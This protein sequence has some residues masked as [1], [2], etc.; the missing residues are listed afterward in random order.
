MWE[1]SQ[2]K[3]SIKQRT[4][5][6]LEK[7]F[8]VI[9]MTILTL[10]F[11]IFFWAEL[12]FDVNMPNWDDYDSV[13]NWLATFEKTYGV[14]RIIDMLFRQHN[15]HRILF[16]RLIELTELYS[17]KTV[18]F[19][20]LDI[21]GALG[22]F[23]IVLFILFLGKR[24]GLR[25]W[26]MIPIPFILL[27]FSQNNLISFSMASIQVYWAILF[28]FLSFFFV[29]K[30]SNFRYTLVGF[31]FSTLASFTS[32]GGLIGFPVVTIYYLFNKKYKIALAWTAC[33]III[34]YIYFVYF[35]YH[36]TT[37]GIASH[38]YAYSHPLEYFL[39]VIRFYGNMARIPL[40]AEI[41]GFFLIFFSTIFLFGNVV[42]R[43]SWFFLSGTF[44][45][46]TGLADGLS[47]ISLGLNAGLASRYTPFGA[48]FM[49]LLYMVAIIYIKEKKMASKIL[50]S[51]AF[52]LSILL[53]LSWIDPGINSLYSTHHLMTSELL[54]PDQRRAYNEIETAMKMKI[55][56]PISGIFLTASFP[57]GSIGNTPLP[58]YSKQNTSVRLMITH[59]ELL[60]PQVISSVAVF[61]GNYGD[62]A[63]GIL[64]VKLC[65][66]SRC[67]EGK[68]PLSESHD[69]SYFDILL[70][71]RLRVAPGDKLSLT[72]TH[73]S[74]DKPD[75]LWL[76]PEMP[77]YPQSLIGPDGPIH[78]KALRIK[79]KYPLQDP[80]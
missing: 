39:Y 53:Y 36:P 16:D 49:V 28:S 21:F 26:M 23:L 72:I 50:V 6:T 75:A 40:I 8:R 44:V 2:F 13:L 32:A 14:S 1:P 60:K 62:T 10:P 54:Y 45:V 66:G 47:R 58:L 35:R 64:A 59:H 56:I 63:N 46:S 25:A 70:A 7:Y 76:W 67:V 61:Q 65:N 57:T 73:E 48:I 42:K 68:R 41:L 34:F 3:E 52:T 37:I 19:V 55:F 15:E 27:T 5:I 20:Y 18:N 31:F 12:R 9:L 29:S 11:F 22:L 17:L 24:S 74:G 43:D 4:M 71:H 69:N 79:L 38:N 51:T 78:G 33:S 80:Q 77:G 30:S